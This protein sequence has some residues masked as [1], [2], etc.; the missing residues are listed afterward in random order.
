MKKSQPDTEKVRLDKWL[1]AARFFKTRALAIAAIKQGKVLFEN[2]K[3]NP[4][5]EVK[6]NAILTIFQGFD[7]KTIAVK[8]L[9]TKRQSAAIAQTLYEETPDSIALREKNARLKQ[10]TKL[11][12][13][14]APRPP[15]RPEKSDRRKIKELRRKG[16]E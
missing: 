12:T 14:S 7:Q 10:E 16:E 3:T 13:S 11:L 6:L 2:Q 8:S 9:E 15:K 4:S 1:W 5:R